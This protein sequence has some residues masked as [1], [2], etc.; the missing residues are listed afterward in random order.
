[1]ILRRSQPHLHR[2]FRLSGAG[3]IA[4]VAFI[5]CNWVILWAGYTTNTVL[6]IIILIGFALY[7]LHHY[8]IAHKSTAEFEWGHIAWLGAWFGGMWILSWFSDIDG[9]IGIL[10]FWWEVLVVAIWSLIV[11]ELAKR[12]AVPAEET[13]QL[14]A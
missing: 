1:M 4:P 9:G 12:A 2:P 8:L 13:A 10:G 7:V 6:F 3:I 5:C 14:M 11:I